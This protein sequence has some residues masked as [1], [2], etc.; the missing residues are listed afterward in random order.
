[1]K[2]RWSSSINGWLRID[3]EFNFTQ[4]IIMPFYRKTYRKL[5]RHFVTL[6]T[7]NAANW[8]VT[9]EMEQLG[10]WYKKLDEIN[11]YLLPASFKCYGW[12]MPKKDIYIPAVT[13]ANLRDYINGDHTRL[14][15]VLRH[16]WAH[17]LADRRPQL[18]S[19]K[20]F[21]ETFGGSYNSSKQVWEFHPDVHVTPYAAT[22]PCEDFAETFHYYL[23]HKGRIPERLKHKREIVRKWKYIASLAQ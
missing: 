17:A 19:G 23:R 15:D 4:R 12:F 22:I 5:S 21:R 6:S 14:T 10:L 1:M 13:G 18:V 11:V 20:R 2:L 7:L 8:Q 16:E 9:T 3:L